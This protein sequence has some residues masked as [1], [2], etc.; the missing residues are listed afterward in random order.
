MD[1]ISIINY[2][3]GNYSSSVFAKEDYGIA[4]EGLLEDFEASDD[5]TDIWV[6]PYDADE[7]PDGDGDRAGELF[8]ITRN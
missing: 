7:Y 5:I 6:L 2:A 3:T 1:F 4:V 8:S